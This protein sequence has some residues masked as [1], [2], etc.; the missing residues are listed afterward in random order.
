MTIT[1]APEARRE[2]LNGPPP[3]V[4]YGQLD[5][6][7]IPAP[8]LPLAEVAAD[9]LGITP[10]HLTTLQGAQLD[11]GQAA[12]FEVRTFPGAETVDRYAVIAYDSPTN[13][14]R[15]ICHADLAKAK[16]RFAALLV[17]DAEVAA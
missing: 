3:Q 4:A 2:V 1:P 10:D 9:L 7:R 5:R 13:R 14:P 12:I 8:Y 11:H 15:V 17:A 16:T 6:D